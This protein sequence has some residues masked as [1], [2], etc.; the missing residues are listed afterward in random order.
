MTNGDDLPDWNREA[1]HKHQPDQFRAVEAP[2]R[3]DVVIAGDE[4]TEQLGM[5][6]LAVVPVTGMILTLRNMFAAE[7]TPST[8][9]IV[10][11]REQNEREPRA[12]FTEPTHVIIVR[13]AE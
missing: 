12:G 8:F 3:A 11:V 10:E 7:V 9:E 5:L 1:P 13:R 6:Y 4:T 2:V